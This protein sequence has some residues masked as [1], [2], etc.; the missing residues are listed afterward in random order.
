MREE[1]ISLL[2]Y[3]EEQLVTDIPDALSSFN[4]GFEELS[5]MFPN[6]TMPWE[7]RIKGDVI[8]ENRELLTIGLSSYIFTGGAHGYGST[9]FLN[10]DKSGGEELESK[11][12]FKNLEKFQEYAE[13]K[14]RIQENIPAQ[15]SINSTGFMFEQDSFYLPENIGFTR[16]GLIL[17][18]NPYEVASYADGTIELTLPLDEVKKFLAVGI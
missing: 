6:E 1:V 10:F 17:L 11:M 2:S 18:Y 16:E 7:A 12:L 15:E 8:F 5:K 14:F 13:T 3:E 9:R 4:L